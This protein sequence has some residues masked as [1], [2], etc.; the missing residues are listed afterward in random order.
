MRQKIIFIAWGIMIFLLGGEANAKSDV[1]KCGIQQ[2]ICTCST[3]VVNDTLLLEKERLSRFKEYVVNYTLLQ[4]LPLYVE[5]NSCDGAAIIM[6]NLVKENVFVYTD[7]EEHDVPCRLLL[8]LNKKGMI[9]D[10][11]VEG[12]HDKKLVERIKK[13]TLGYRQKLLDSRV[14]KEITLTVELLLPFAGNYV[15]PEAGLTELPRVIMAF[16]YSL[17][18]SHPFAS[19]RRDVFVAGSLSYSFVVERDG[20]LTRFLK[21]HDT[22]V[23]PY[24]FE[25][26]MRRRRFY[27]SGEVDVCVLNGEKIPLKIDVAMD[28][29]ASAYSFQCHL[30]EGSKGSVVGINKQ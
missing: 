23:P 20:S 2:S 9:T 19:V 10:C 16:A 7:T 15:F 25:D 12:L 13:I 14:K 18:N 21:K 29:D 22:L 27:S 28:F 30:M 24:L 4:N 8:Q 6:H 5:R 3:L 17:M 1:C 11:T 26:H